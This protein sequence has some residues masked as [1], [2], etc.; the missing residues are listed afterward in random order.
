[1]ADRDIV[2]KQIEVIRNLHDEVF[3]LVKKINE[4]FRGL[5]W[6]FKKMLPLSE[7]FSQKAELLA[8]LNEQ[9]DRLLAN[10]TEED[11]AYIIKEYGVAND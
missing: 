3:F 2:I 8:D 11:R 7:E 10:L 5:P 6:D 9:F 4:S 1:M